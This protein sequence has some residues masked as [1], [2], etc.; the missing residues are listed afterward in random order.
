M[1]RLLDPSF[2]GWD[3]SARKSLTFSNPFIL[4]TIDRKY[5]FIV[6]QDQPEDSPPPRSHLLGLVTK[7]N[8]HR[9][10]LLSTHLAEPSCLC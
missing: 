9:K 4:A 3:R 2:D 6:D 5:F 1:I 7:S 8:G 10:Y